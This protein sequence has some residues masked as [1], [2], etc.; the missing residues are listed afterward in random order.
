[1]A[2]YVRQSAASIVAG[3]T[4]RATHFNAEYNA[5]Q[6][7]FSTGSGH[8]HDG[9]VGEGAYVPLIREGNSYIEIDDVGTGLARFVVDGVTQAQLI[10]PSVPTNNNELVT[11][12]Y[13]D[14]VAFNTALPSQTGNAGKFVTTNGTNA[15][16]GVVDTTGGAAAASITTA[17]TLTSTSERVRP[18]AMTT[19]AQSVTLPD[20]TTLSEGGPTFVFP[21]TGNRV[22]GIRAN[23]GALIATVWPGYTTTLY[24][25]D[26]S[27]AAGSWAVEGE[28][29]LLPLTICDATLT[30][31]LTQVVEAAVRLTDTLS[32]HF[33]RNASGHPFA[34]AIDHSTYPATVG[35]PV[36]IVA[37][38]RVVNEAIRISNTKATVV[39]NATSNNV[40]NITVSGTTCTVSSAGS[41]S[42]F[43]NKSFTG[44]PL[45]A[46]LGANRDLFVSIDVNGTAVDAQAVDCSGTNPS[47]GSAVN[48]VASGGQVAHAIYRVTDST[49]LAI[50]TDD[51]GTPG[52]PFSIRAVV[53][54]LSG[55][56]ITVGTSAGINDTTAHT[57]A[58]ASIQLNSTNY[59]LAFRNTT[60][61]TVVVHIGVS[62]TTVTFGT[63]GSTT[64][65]LGAGNDSYT[66]GGGSRFQPNL[67]KLSDTSALLTCAGT[68]I[69]AYHAVVSH[70]A[71]VVS[72]ATP[73]RNLWDVGNGAN[74]PQAVDGFLASND[75]SAVNA[76]F[77]VTI[78][79][80]TL[81]VA[82]TWRLTGFEPQSTSA[83]RFGL[84]GGV[85]AVTQDAIGAS[86]STFFILHAFRFR[87]GGPPV[88][89]G[90]FTFN[91]L[92]ANN[93]RVPVEV[94]PTR[95]AWSGLTV[96]QGSSTT[97]LVGIQILEFPT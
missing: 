89:L 85:R 53:L 1:M 80:E 67:F 52:T 13:V 5:L 69:G 55:T 79:G 95:V 48:I 47:A 73:L 37:A 15:S 42:A 93:S 43:R 94:A 68:G 19:D 51:S 58:S 30:S 32:L 86:G 72:F 18:V 78:S 29:A 90:A 76:I 65:D 31:T 23:G 66:A 54:S 41:A 64:L 12:T 40:F 11:K 46:A 4:V 45:V 24:L 91:N 92:I 21:N 56:T 49:A 87:A 9:S 34:V 17:T 26:N 39:L 97:S 14:G 44:P 60:P 38:D 74:F 36:I 27:T 20:A 96:A 35:T 77:S 2:G 7:A 57:Y 61:L 28:N 25:R 22:A 88:Y 59:L 63:P 50:Y 75:A 81:S 62:G 16:W 8:K 10:T 33:A 83:A 70:A 82:G 3:Q 84:S 6:T 71:G